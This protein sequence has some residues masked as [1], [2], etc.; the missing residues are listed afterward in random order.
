MQKSL[1]LFGW[2]TEPVI[3]TEVII[4]EGLMDVFCDLVYGSGKMNTK[5]STTPS[6]LVKKPFTG[7]VPAPLAVYP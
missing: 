6:K 1:L 7:F 2:D 3:G 5:L 4:E